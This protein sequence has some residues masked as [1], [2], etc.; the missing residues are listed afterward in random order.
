[1][2]VL[3]IDC[4][5]LEKINPLVSEALESFFHNEFSTNKIQGTVNIYFNG[6][7]GYNEDELNLHWNRFLGEWEEIQ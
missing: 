5:S 1:M 2:K 4:E 7:I 3:E 6:E